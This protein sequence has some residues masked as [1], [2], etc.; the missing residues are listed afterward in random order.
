MAGG[1]EAGVSLCAR[2]E[3]QSLRLLETRSEVGLQVR[4][5]P[6]RYVYSRAGDSDN[7][8]LALE[9][10]KVDS[11]AHVL[12]ADSDRRDSISDLDLRLGGEG[13][14]RRVRGLGNGRSDSGWGQLWTRASKMLSGRRLRT[15]P[16]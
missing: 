7:N 3:L 5:H 4:R 14:E 12:G 2:E 1:G 10:A 13:G 6:L 15:Y 11:G 9:G 16:S 8:V